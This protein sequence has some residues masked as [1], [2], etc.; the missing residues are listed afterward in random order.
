[1][2]GT[3]TLNSYVFT[4]R[5]ITFG[6]AHRSNPNMVMR[7]TRG[8]T[9]RTIVHLVE[10]ERESHTVT[11]DNISYLE[12]V[13][14]QKVAYSGRDGMNQATLQTGTLTITGQLQYPI[15]IIENFN[16]KRYKTQYNCAS[17]NQQLERRYTVTLDII[18]ECTYE[19]GN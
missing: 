1:M 8:E 3:L 10:A 9:L 18:G 13:N 2:T 19:Q 17:D 12:V 7:R 4:F 5:D 16:G 14:L 6:E 15:E 11:I